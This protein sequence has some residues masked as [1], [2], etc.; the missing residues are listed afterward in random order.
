MSQFFGAEALLDFLFGT[1]STCLTISD[2]LLG[3]SG[4]TFPI[5]KMGRYHF[6]VYVY[7]NANLALERYG[8]LTK[9]SCRKLWGVR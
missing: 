8:Q 1:E 7:A 5:W 4:S 2:S 6:L 3:H 9:R